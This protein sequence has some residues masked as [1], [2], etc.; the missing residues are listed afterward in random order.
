MERRLCENLGVAF[1]FSKG[2]Y[3]TDIDGLFTW[4][5]SDRSRGNTFNW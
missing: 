4:F 3:K 2:A 5:N 1:Q